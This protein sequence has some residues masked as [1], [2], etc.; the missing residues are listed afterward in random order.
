MLEREG[1]L[2]VHEGL[3]YQGLHLGQEGVL[4]GVLEVLE[5]LDGVQEEL[6]EPIGSNSGV[7]WDYTDSIAGLWHSAGGSDQLDYPDYQVQSGDPAYGDGNIQDVSSLYQSH[8][9]DPAIAKFVDSLGQSWENDRQPD[10]LWENVIFGRPSEAFEKAGVLT[11]WLDKVAE[12]FGSKP[13]SGVNF[14]ERVAERRTANLTNILHGKLP[15]M[16]VIGRL[17]SKSLMSCVSI[18]CFFSS[19][20]R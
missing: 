19:G 16:L 9:S 1:W 10:N 2:P 6:L 12:A 15:K 3:E 5:V 18:F 11:V 14:Q 4:E 13:A 20:P 7:Y 8:Y 17:D